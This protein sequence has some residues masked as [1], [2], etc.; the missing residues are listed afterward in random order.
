MSHWADMLFFD[1]AMLTST[2]SSET[3]NVT[4]AHNDIFLEI[5]SVIYNKMEWQSLGQTS[6]ETRD[7]RLWAAAGMKSCIWNTAQLFTFHSTVAQ[8]LEDSSLVNTTKNFLPTSS[9]HWFMCLPGTHRRLCLLKSWLGSDDTRFY[10]RMCMNQTTW[11]V[12][13]SRLPHTQ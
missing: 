7:E 10:L 1:S 3:E 13:L 6:S 5:I 9:T 4:N 2:R 12:P 11:H 8:G